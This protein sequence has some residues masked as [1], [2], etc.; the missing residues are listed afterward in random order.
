MTTNTSNRH[1]TSAGLTARSA[2]RRMPASPNGPPHPRRACRPPYLLAACCVLALLVPCTVRAQDDLSG[3][4][5]QLKAYH[6]GESPAPLDKLAALVSAARLS[7]ALRKEAARS[8]AAVLT[9]DASFE[10]KQFA[11]RQL[12]FVADDEQV[13]A[14]AGLLSDAAL[15][16][17]AL[18]ALARIHTPAAADALAL[19]LPRSSGRTEIE[20]LDTLAD[21]RDNR[22]I[23]A[24]SD[25]LH[26]K[27][28]ALRDAAAFA[29]AKIGDG[30]ALETLLDAYTHASGTER[31]DLGEALFAAASRAGATPA[32]DQIVTLI[33]H[34]PANPVLAAA[35]LRG[36]AHVRGAR[37]L[38]LL[39]QALA[40]DGTR[41]QDVAA[42]AIRELPGKAVAERL[43]ATV[44]K[45]HG[46]GQILAIDILGDRGDAAA[47]PAIGALCRSSYPA[48]RAAA[49]HAA[50]SLGD[51]SVVPLL[52]AAASGTAEEKAAARDSLVRIRGA[53]ADR[54]L[55]A[56]LDTA[57]PAG[58]VQAIQ[59]LGQRGA[60]G[61]APRLLKAA[62]STNSGVSAAALRVL[63]DQ[64]APSLLP[65]LVD[66]M[67]SLPSDARDPALDAITQIARRAPES[68][69][70]TLLLVDRF[71]GATR[72][73][74][75]VSLLTAIG[76]VGGPGALEL[77]R[78]SAADASAP[79][80]L[81]ALSALAEWPTDEPMNDLLRAARTSQDPGQR[82]IAL[83]GYLRMA[84][85]GEQR[86]PT[87][88]LALF[89]D[90][91][92]IA[93]RPEEKRLML[94]GVARVPSLEALQYAIK[95]SGDKAVRPEAELAIVE[96]ARATL[97]AA[98]ETTRAALGTISQSGVNEEARK[99]A[100]ALLAAAR[101]FGDFDMAWEVSPS[102]ER[103]GADYTHL[104]DI[105]FPPEA[106]GAQ[107]V[108][109]RLMPV[110]GNAEQPWLLDLLA[111]LGGEQRVAYLQSAVRVNS[112]RDL[113][114][115]M[116]SDDGIKAWWNGAVALAHN[117]ARAVA[118]GQERATVHAHAGWN[119]LM[120]KVTQNNQ[121]WGACVRITN[122]DGTPATGIT[123][124][125]PAAD[126]GSAVQH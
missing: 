121:G 57:S 95:L 69:P 30:H 123:Y 104:F 45:M 94:A 78:R 99:R 81:A 40:E 107:D 115:E 101:R 12:V 19:A 31:A 27:D 103:D 93:V 48:V 76:Q 82:A 86:S 85:S 73:E 42:M 36:I 118:P 51:A 49:L 20:I 92:A 119:G 80:R 109:W 71:A 4:V 77:L 113:V 97:G 21:L 108:P 1:D 43:A 24:A 106:A 72:T 32:A 22:V 44:G 7:P 9:G 65:S 68:G 16:H 54:A 52:L 98:P 33:E 83:R 100:D 87:Q 11:C 35:A 120:L 5:Q 23:A 124:S 116:G 62:R 34:N 10:A 84:A 105:A 66:L 114:L 47:A 41:R 90:A 111:L 56:A 89:K 112:P 15:S 3:L 39:L 63:R 14:L 67:L 74:D 29:L 70:A 55:L 88:A 59:A 60:I 58:Q 102:Y 13:P 28:S 53:S 91:D 117:T 18:L 2:D 122:A 6:Y 110:G 37:A 125:V 25:R 75:R 79:V 26:A 126:P 61:I 50:G 96:I 38:P 64:G 8:L 17:Y 46:R